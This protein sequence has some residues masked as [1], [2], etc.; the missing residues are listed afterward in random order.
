MYIT[1]SLFSPLATLVPSLSFS[2]IEYNLLW[3]C[4][5]KEHLASCKCFMGPHV[6]FSLYILISSRH[7][8]DSP[9]V[10]SVP[11]CPSPVRSTRQHCLLLSIVIA[12][13]EV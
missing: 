4:S 11:L 7:C 3:S 8:R 2:F 1:L 9:I 6:R 13:S 5:N 12:D 10:V